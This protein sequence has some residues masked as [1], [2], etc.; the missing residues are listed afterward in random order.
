M[1][2]TD[3]SRNGLNETEVEN[4]NASPECSPGEPLS[5]PRSWPGGSLKPLLRFLILER[6]VLKMRRQCTSHLPRKEEL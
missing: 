4:P 5:L 1:H 6:D 2:Q 3:R